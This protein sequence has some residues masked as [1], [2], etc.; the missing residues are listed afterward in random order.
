MQKDYN[1]TFV[2][3]AQ[4]AGTTTIHELLR[5]HSDI[6]LPSIK[7]THFFSDDKVYR[8]GLDWYLRQFDSSKNILCEVDP[9]YLFYK[10]ASYRIKKNLDNSKFIVIFRKPLDRAFSHYLMSCY[11]GHEK[12]S[13]IKAIDKENERLAS[14]VDLFSFINHSYIS[15]GDYQKQLSLY[16]NEFNKSNFLF[17]N[18]DNLFPSYNS[19]MINS[20][21]E[22]I[23]INN[24]FNLEEMPTHNKKRMVK[25][26][27][28]RDMIYRESITKK[29][30]GS[31]IPSDK[32]KLRIKKF[33]DN[34]NSKDFDPNIYTTEYERVMNEL[35]KK[36]LKWSNEQS[37]LLEKSTGLDLRSWRYE[38]V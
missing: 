24:N 18:F 37:E 32:L 6:S 11:R 10:Q 7:E 27:F 29:I 33:I 36:Y 34:F 8:K 4:K 21:C 2:I 3:G 30:A 17:I 14:D 1:F 22:F 38:D 31:I 5:A 35:P 23:G 12:L 19:K 16:L 25:S 28:I 13:F 15:R 20:I 26:N 9:S